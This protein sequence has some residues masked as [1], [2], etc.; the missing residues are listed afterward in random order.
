LQARIESEPTKPVSGPP[1]AA[2]SAAEPRALSPSQVPTPPPDPEEPPPAAAQPLDLRGRYQKLIEAVRA[3]RK[4]GAA[5]ALEHGS[6]QKIDKSG[7]RVA[8]RK[9]DGRALILAD[10]EVRSACEAAFERFL[11]FRAPLVVI[12]EDAA[13]GESVAEAKQK[14]RAQASS[15]RIAQAKAHPA[16]RAAVEVLGGEIEDV[17]DLGE[18]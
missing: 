10:K 11:G 4:P 16:V 13:P 8:F 18:E 6:P 12:E 2:P 3:A 5:S 15:S 17:R 1:A 7:V 9:G 14:Q